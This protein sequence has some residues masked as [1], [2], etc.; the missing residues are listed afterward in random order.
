MQTD[1]THSAYSLTTGAAADYCNV[2]KKTI[3]RW[4]DAG[5]LPAFITPGGHRR[6]RLADLDALFP[7]DKASA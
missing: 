3:R 1:I 6:Y 7:S 4:T 2:D 5:K